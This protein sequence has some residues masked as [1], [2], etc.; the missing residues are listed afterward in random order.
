M[1]L[2]ILCLEQFSDQTGFSVF[3][4]LLQFFL[5]GI[6][7]GSLCSKRGVNIGAF[8]GSVAVQK[9]GCFLF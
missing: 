4:T 9:Q 2:V 3:C 7:R 1:P 8:I 6:I 5:Y